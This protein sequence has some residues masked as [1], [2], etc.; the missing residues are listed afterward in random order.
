[1]TGGLKLALCKATRAPLLVNMLIRDVGQWRFPMNQVLVAGES[2]HCPNEAG[3]G[4]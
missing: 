4:S 2:G 1:M 3:I